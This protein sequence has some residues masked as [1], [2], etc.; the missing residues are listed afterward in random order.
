MK[1]DE[2]IAPNYWENKDI[3]LHV[4]ALE[5]SKLRDL[6]EEQKMMAGFLNPKLQYEYLEER[7]LNKKSPDLSPVNALP[8]LVPPCAAG[9]KPKII[10]FAL[11]SPKPVTG[12]PQYF[13]LIFCF[14]LNQLLFLV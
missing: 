5:E 4:S 8:V 6:K 13:S 12:L 9:A 7:L 10:N 3:F 11:L 2:I 1:V 14:Q